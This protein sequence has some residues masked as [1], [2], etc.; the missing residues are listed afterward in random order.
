MSITLF[1]WP[2]HDGPSDTCNHAA[3]Y[4]PGCKKQAHE[5]PSVKDFAADFELTPEQF[6]RHEEGT[7]NP[8][9][10]HFLC[11]DC[12]IRIEDVAGG[13]LVGPQGRRWICP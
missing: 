5:I 13:R 6:I 1:T 3:P 2:T 11:E 10:E 4:C 9:N 12:F 8:V 7:Y